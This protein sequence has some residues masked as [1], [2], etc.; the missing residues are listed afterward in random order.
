MLYV[1][2]LTNRW[3]KYRSIQKYY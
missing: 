3:V 1:L 2:L